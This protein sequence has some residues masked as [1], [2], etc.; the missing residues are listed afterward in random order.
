MI[1]IDSSI[2]S[3]DV[4][5][6]II[7]WA[8]LKDVGT[9]Q[10]INYGIIDLR[11]VG[12]NHNDNSLFIKTQYADNFIKSLLKKHT[13]IEQIWIE[14]ALES[15]SNSSHSTA[16]LNRYNAMLSYAIYLETGAAPY[17]INPIAARNM[18]HIPISIRMERPEIKETVYQWVVEKFP[19]L[20]DKDLDIGKYDIS[21]AIVVGL[22]GM[23]YN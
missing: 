23:E 12:N 22:A 13:N 7:G 16:V 15:V 20:K 5:T 3:L 1:Q 6:N 10:L 11:N 2:L 9:V 21:D 8:I 17:Y 18:L 19:I 4:S 14:E